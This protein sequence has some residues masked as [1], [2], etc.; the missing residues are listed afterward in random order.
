M[1]HERNI[2]VRKCSLQEAGALGFHA[3]CQRDVFR[4][5]TGREHDCFAERQDVR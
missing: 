3:S 1:S 5:V 2:Q 4:G